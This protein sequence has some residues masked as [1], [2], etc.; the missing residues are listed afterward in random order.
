MCPTG[1]RRRSD[2]E[3]FGGVQQDATP[4]RDRVG[5]AG[6]LHQPDAGHCHGRRADP[7][8]ARRATRHQSGGCVG[9]GRVGPAGVRVG[10]AG[11]RVGSAGVRVGRQQPGAERAAGPERVQRQQGRRQRLQGPERLLP[12]QQRSA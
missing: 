3:N 7:T 6:V 10:A 4:D 5:R 8:E 12:R 11:V 1:G 9:R 2:D